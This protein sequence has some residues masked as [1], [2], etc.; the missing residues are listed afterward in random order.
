MTEE[1]RVYAQAN[2]ALG[3]LGALLMGDEAH[4]ELITNAIREIDYGLDALLVAAEKPEAAPAEE[5]RSYAWHSTGIP[6]FYSAAPSA[7]WYLTYSRRLGTFAVLRIVWDNE[8]ESRWI[9]A[10]GRENPVD[11]WM[12]LPDP[13]GPFGDE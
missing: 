2:R 12:E 9:D 5:P 11:Y 4:R 8:N 6:G 10:G 7:G 1:L 13:P 3:A